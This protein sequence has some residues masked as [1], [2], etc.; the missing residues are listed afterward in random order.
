MCYQKNLTT[1]SKT[2]LGYYLAGLIEGDG[3]FYSD[4]VRYSNFLRIY[5]HKK[6]RPIAEKIQNVLCV[7]RVVDYNNEQTCIFI[8]SDKKGL[9]KLL[10]LING[11]FVGPFK[12]QQLKKYKIDQRL[13]ITLKPAL[14][15]VSLNNTWL[16]GFFEADGSAQISIV[17]D[18]T[19][20]TG[21]SIRLYIS[22]NQKNRLLLDLIAKNFIVLNE[23]RP[24]KVNFYKQK[25][26]KNKKASE[27]HNFTV[28]SLS[29][30]KIWLNYFDKFHL[31]G[32][33]YGQVLK[34]KLCYELMINKKHLTNEGLK[35]IEILQKELRNIDI[36]NKK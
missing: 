30:I 2:Q 1:F 19:Y 36:I 25:A 20:I 33:K 28:G 23:K 12:I 21:K 15:V 24:A 29:K 8:I 27:G 31:Q 13:G 7:G 9:L 11:K 17:K 6:D 26:N 22:L 3:N 32:R 14:N 18:K 34:L 4:S 16:V 10:K 35:Q 5:F